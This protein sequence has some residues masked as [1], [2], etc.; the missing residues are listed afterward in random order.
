MQ[1]TNKQKLQKELESLLKEKEELEV[2]L[3]DSQLQ[4]EK[5]NQELLTSNHRIEELLNSN[6]WKVTSGLRYIAL[7]VKKCKC[8]IK[9][10][11]ACILYRVIVFIKNSPFLKQILLSVINKLPFLKSK[12]TSFYYSRNSELNL[13]KLDARE[14]GIQSGFNSASFPKIPTIPDTILLKQSHPSKC[15]IRF[16]GHFEGDYSLA[17]VNR[18]L[19]KELDRLTHGQ[20]SFIPYHGSKIED[21][22]TILNSSNYNSFKSLTRQITKRNDELL[23]SIVHHYPMIKDAFESD[24]RGIIYFWEETSVPEDQIFFLNENF[25]IIWVASSST[26]AALINSG[27][28][29]PVFTIP[30]GVDKVTNYPQ[31]PNTMAKTSKKEVFRYL[32]I[33]SCFP[34]KGIDILFSAYLNA[35]TGQDDVE[36]FIKTFPNPHNNVRALWKKLSSAYPDPPKLRIDERSYTDDQLLAL[37]KSADVVVLPS[38]GEGFNLPAAEALALAIPVITTGYSAQTDFCTDDNCYLVEF[39]FEKSNSH[40]AAIDS[41]WVVPNLFDLTEKLKKSYR[42]I[43]NTDSFHIKKRVSCAEYIKQIYKWENSA[44]GILNSIGSLDSLDKQEQLSVGVVSPWGISCGIAEYSLR[45]LQPLLTNRAVELEIYADDR[46]CES[47]KV[48]SINTISCWRINDQKS[49]LSL[50]QQFDDSKK[51]VVFVQH[52]PS[53]FRLSEAICE[54]LAILSNRGKIVCLELHATRPF[55]KEEYLSDRSSHFLRKIDRIIVHKVE[56]LNNLLMLGLVNNVTLLPHGVVKAI[57]QPLI[58]ENK[59]KK[60]ILGSFGFALPHKGIDEIIKSIP[61]ISKA[62]SVD[63]ELIAVNSSLDDRSSKVISDCK[64]IAIKLNVADKINWVTDFHTI[65]EC[66]NILSSVDYVIFPYKETKESASGAVTIGLS[67]MKPVLVSP[68][69]IFSDLEEVVYHME[70]SS[71]NDICNAIKKLESNSLLR[72]SLLDKQKNWLKDRD[73]GKISERLA[74]MFIGLKYQKMMGLITREEQCIVQSEY[75]KKKEKQL[76]IDVSEIYYRDANTGIQRTIKKIINAWK[77]NE[78]QGFTVRLVYGDQLTG[79]RYTD[80]LGFD[81]LPNYLLDQPIQI[82]YGDV[83]LGLDLTAHLFPEIERFL[84]S[85]KEQGLIIYYV[86]YD[87]IP[88]LYPEYTIPSISD[89]FHHW[90][91]GLLSYSDGLLCISNSVA[92]DVRNWANRFNVGVPEKIESFH[93][94]GDIYGDYS[95]AVSNNL[96]PL[97]IEKLLAEK[98]VFLMVGTVEPRKGYSDILAAFTYFWKMNIDIVLVI[99]GKKGWMVD[100]LTKDIINHNEFNNK[101]F[102]YDSVD[103]ETLRYLYKHSKA[104]ISASYCEGFGLPIIEAARYGTPLIVRDIPIFR[105]VSGEY[106]YY[107]PNSRDVKIIISSIEEWLDLYI[108]DQYP[109][110]LDMPCLT[111]EQSAQNLLQIILD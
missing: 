40:L 10:R 106:A 1:S 97:S 6:S 100:S 83:F 71:P 13:S 33:S 82:N 50:L 90:I 44:Q 11:I 103:D 73:W 21:L 9:E 7:F 45:L 35:F 105:E 47:G 69:E 91:Q 58:S 52:Q 3:H 38:R 51:D 75:W 56:D 27:C 61:L 12:L 89:A 108:K 55:V 16:T 62:L 94:G 66:Q 2:I 102:W 98:F 29:I 92:Q 81:Q 8:K 46:L 57:A 28:R 67:I 101:L 59:R 63:V 14:L 111:W 109:K 4:V 110:S 64:K 53:L 95:N 54:Q 41:C 48:N 31:S 26:K 84:K 18:G 76:L 93:L 80:I 39:N 78:P 22:S 70:G 20:V 74:N 15:W 49:V 99:V 77:K 68:L 72:T 32:H 34:R 79:Y 24:V 107:F 37:Y 86:I 43:Q 87:L 104:L 42:D 65:E 60:V 30:L 36:L 88:L 85:Y 96:I 25:D 17:I 5:L 19:T 23:I